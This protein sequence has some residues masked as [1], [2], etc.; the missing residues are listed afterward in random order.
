MSYTVH[1]F[2]GGEKLYAAQ[3]NE[4]DEEIKNTSDAIEGMGTAA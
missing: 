2:V 3:L 4:M 1:H